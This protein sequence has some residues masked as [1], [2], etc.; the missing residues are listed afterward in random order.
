MKF[1]ETNPCG[2]ATI[3]VFCHPDISPSHPSGHIWCRS[4][5]DSFLALQFETPIGRSGFLRE[6]LADK[7]TCS[8]GQDHI[9]VVAASLT[10]LSA[11][12]LETP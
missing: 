3:H 7:H 10:W 6:H 9:R 12:S 11:C 2:K 4:T 8:H 5:F 1:S